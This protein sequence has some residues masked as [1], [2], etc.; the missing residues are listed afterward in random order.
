M[1]DSSQ[2][3]R[4]GTLSVMKTSDPTVPVAHFPIDEEEITIGRD[5]SCSVRLY[6][7]TVSRLHCKIVFQERKVR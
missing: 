4:F 7:E 1:M 2:V 5:P 6:Y 3:G